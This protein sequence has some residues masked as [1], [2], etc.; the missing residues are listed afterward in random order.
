MSSFGNRFDHDGLL[1][2]LVEILAGLEDMLRGIADAADHAVLQRVGEREPDS[3]LLIVAKVLAPFFVF[4]M[5]FPVVS[6]RQLP[7]R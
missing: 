5:P 1:D 3:R 6:T 2:G 7:S 4:V